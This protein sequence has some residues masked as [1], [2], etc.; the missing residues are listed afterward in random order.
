[1]IPLGRKQFPSSKADLAQ[2]LDEAL[3][4]YASKDGQIVDVHARVFPY[5]DEIAINLDGA[6]LNLPPPQPPKLA[7]KRTPA[8]E[9][10]V[11]TVSARQISVRGLPFNLRLS[12]RDLVFHKAQDEK[13]DAAIV[14]H[15]VRDGTLSI[16]AAQ[17]DLEKAIEQIARE[18]GRGLTI[19]QVRLAMRAR[20]Q[21]S[22]AIEV[23]VQAKKL[24]LRA[25]ID[26]SGQLDI[27][28]EFTI[29]ISS[30]KCKSDGGIGAIACSTL[31]PMFRKLEEK[32]FSLKSLPLGE[33]HVRDI[34]L[35]VAD[36]IELTADFGSKS[37]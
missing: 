25:K 24:F 36:T 6:Q 11:T 20:G 23:Q 34:R 17:L 32:S 15:A 35:A 14:V 21:R 1:M 26:I 22:L 10:A 9:A 31:E 12:A 5:L 7:G 13:G 16:S 2:A 33:V 29:K 28:D 3:H 37:E 18:E 19:E 30:L 4:R 8:F 27:D